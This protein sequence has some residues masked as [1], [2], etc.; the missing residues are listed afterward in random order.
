MAS[1]YMKKLLTSLAIKE[2]Q[3]KASLRVHLIS[4]RMTPSKKEATDAGEG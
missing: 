4:V 3:I 2:M 1:K